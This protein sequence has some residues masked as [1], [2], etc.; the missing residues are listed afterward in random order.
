MDSEQSAWM[1]TYGLL[2]AA[3]VQLV[4][5]VVGMAWLGWWL[6]ARW[7]TSPVFTVVS[8]VLGSVGGF[9]NLWRILKWKERMDAKNPD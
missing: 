5:A 1:R 3:A 9:W 2:G 4:G 8:V 7:G 6:D